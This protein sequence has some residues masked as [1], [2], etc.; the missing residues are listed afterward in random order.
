MTKTVG[1]LIL[2]ICKESRRGI[3][4]GT[5]IAGL[6]INVQLVHTMVERPIPDSSYR[7]NNLRGAQRLSALFTCQ[8]LGPILLYR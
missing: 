3:V 1:G 7:I 5:R 2:F 6:C 8:G 4:G